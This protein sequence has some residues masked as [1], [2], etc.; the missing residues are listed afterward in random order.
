M[1]EINQQ[2]LRKDT[3]E[4]LTEYPNDGPIPNS[5][6]KFGAAHVKL[7]HFPGDDEGL[8]YESELDSMPN[9]DGMVTSWVDCN[10]RVVWRVRI[11]I[12]TQ[13]TPS[14]NGALDVYLATADNQGTP[15]CDAGLTYSDSADAAFA[16]D[17]RD[18]LEKIGQI[19]TDATPAEYIV[20]FAFEAPNAHSIAIVL[21]NR[22]GDALDSDGNDVYLFGS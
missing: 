7:L 13:G 14:A 6:D 18:E 4:E 21:W 19:D 2:L 17:K 11:R 20:S 5:G 22:T 9:A 10:G 15:L 3:V 12:T 1:P 8:D 16:T